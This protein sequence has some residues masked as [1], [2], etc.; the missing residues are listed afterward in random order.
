MKKS[1]VLTRLE[2]MYS[3][4]ETS[5][6]KTMEDIL[7]RFKHDSK[8]FY[9]YTFFKWNT[10][11][12]PATYDVWHQPRF[13]KPDAFPG[14]ILRRVSPTGGWSKIIWALPHQ[15][16]MHLYES[17]KMFADQLVS[18]SVRKYLAGEL[19]LEEEKFEKI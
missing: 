11:T 18:E 17:G 10:H 16:G 6:P 19:D 14:T 15:E 9:I 8:D 13:S 2:E 1:A 7:S 3:Q 4:L 5:W 12:V